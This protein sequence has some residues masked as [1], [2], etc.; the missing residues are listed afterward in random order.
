[1]FDD[2]IELLQRLS[3]LQEKNPAC[4]I[5]GKVG[6]KW[7]PAQED[8]FFILEAFNFEG[9]IK[10]LELIGGLEWFVKLAAEAVDFVAPSE[11]RATIREP[12][13]A[14]EPRLPDSDCKCDGC[15]GSVPERRL[16]D[17]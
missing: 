9:A 17:A 5:E 3:E 16:K 7:T 2:M 8:F 1:M 14:R 15:Q 10:A 4:R 12:T 6:S 13:S 11:T